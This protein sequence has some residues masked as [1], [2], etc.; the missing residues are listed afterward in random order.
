[1]KEKKIFFIIQHDFNPYIKTYKNLFTYSGVED[2][3]H[4]LR[5]SKNCWNIKVKESEFDIM[6][7]N[8]LI[9]NQNYKVL[10]QIW[11]VPSLSELTPY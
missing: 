10:N 1:M 2:I 5:F 7:Y 4:K 9:N 3:S 6:T 11:R 8:F